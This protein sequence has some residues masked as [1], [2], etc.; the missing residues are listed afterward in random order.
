M[1]DADIREVRKLQE[2]LLPNEEMDGV[3]RQRT[4]K[5]K[6]LESA[7]VLDDGKGDKNDHDS[8]EE[9]SNAYDEIEEQNENAWRK[10]RYE[11]ERFLNEQ[12]ESSDKKSDVITIEKNVPKLSATT[13]VSLRKNDLDHFLI[14]KNSSINGQTPPIRG[15]FL[16]RDEKTL[17]KLSGLTK[18]AGSNGA[19]HN[20]NVTGVNKSKNFVFVTLTAEECEAKRKRKAEEELLGASMANGKNYMKKRKLQPKRERCFIDRLLEEPLNK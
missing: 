7:F 17:H 6:N 18:N 19:G 16:V 13:N 3:G 8:K 11:R 1:L 5:W 15:S 12:G 20:I 10:M 9:L 4:Y 14:T 2:F